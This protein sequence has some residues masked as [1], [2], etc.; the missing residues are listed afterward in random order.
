VCAGAQT[1]S[2]LPLPAHLTGGVR[3]SGSVECGELSK[4][5]SKLKQFKG[6]ILYPESPLL[7]TVEMSFEGVGG[8][9]Q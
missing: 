9:I 1:G 7:I 8:A 2:A 4:K 3:F 6:S 5:L